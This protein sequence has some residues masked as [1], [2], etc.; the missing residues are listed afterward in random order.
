MKRS[1]VYL[2]APVLAIYPTLR[3]ELFK[4]VK[5]FGGFYTVDISDIESN[6][7]LSQLDDFY[8]SSILEYFFQKEYSKEVNVELFSSSKNGDY[9]VITKKCSFLNGLCKIS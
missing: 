7:K 8:V 5:D 1:V 4:I 3:G 9:F 6:S 2:D